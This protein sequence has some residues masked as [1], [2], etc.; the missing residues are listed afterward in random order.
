MEGND[1]TARLDAA[2]AHL[3]P[4]T[5]HAATALILGSGLGGFTERITDAR[6]IR[7]ADIPG[8]PA[9][10]VEGHA[11]ELVCGKVNGAQVLAFSGRF[12]YYEGH[13]ARVAAWPAFLSARLGAK[14][15]VVSN[16]AGGIN[17]GFDVGDIM[18]ITDHINLTG[19]NPLIGPHDAS[20][21][22]RFPDMSRAYCPELAQLA[23]TIAHERGI[24]L[25]EGV[26]LGITGP[27]YETAAEIRAF[28][29]LGAD[30]VGMSTVFEV[31]AAAAMGL[32]VLGFSVIS[33]MATGLAE[34]PHAHEHVLAAAVRAAEHLGSIVSGMLCGD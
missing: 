3:E 16:A 5:G 23:R 2:A 8:F 10:G 29:A 21:G 12:H 22:P 11:G 17:A 31:I 20:L 32:N 19:T 28:R 18:L 7:Y 9:A 26:Y 30:A 33:N 27:S 14:R 4:F 25:R 13:A 15:L 1:F 24:P 6:R 34:Q